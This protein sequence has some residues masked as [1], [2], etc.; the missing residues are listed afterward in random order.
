[1]PKGAK[2][3]SAKGKGTARTP[4]RRRLDV[5]VP[6]TSSAVDAATASTSAET[7]PK[8]RTRALENS[9]NE[10]SF[11]NL[12]S[13]YHGVNL[14]PRKLDLIMNAPTPREKERA[15]KAKELRKRIERES[16]SDSDSE[17]KHEKS[18]DRPRRKVARKRASPVETD[19][20]SEEE[21]A[22]RDIEVSDSGSDYAPSDAMEEG[23]EQDFS[24]FEHDQDSEGDFQPL[25]P[26]ISDSDSSTQSEAV[27]PRRRII[28]VSTRRRERVTGTVRRG[29]ARARARGRGRGR[30]RPT[31]DTL[32]EDPEDIANGWNLDNTA[33]TKI[34]F[35]GTPGLTCEAPTTVLGFFQLFFPLK[36]LFFLM[37]ETNDYA[38]YVR[39]ELKKPS[40]YHWIGCTLVDIA[41]YIGMV[42]WM[43]VIRLPE[44]RMYWS[45]NKT[46]SLANFS[47][48]MSRTKYEMMAKYFHTYNRRAI[49]KNNQDKLIVLRPVMEFIQDRCKSVYM[50]R[51]NLSL[52]EGILKWKGRLSI[53]IYNPMK[54][55]KYGIKFY[56]LCE[57][58][59]GYVLDFNVY[60]G[61]SSS[62]RDIV[63]NLME[64]HL[65]KGHHLFMDNYYNQVS[66]CD[67]LYEK[68]THCSGT[69]RLGRGG[70]KALQAIKAAGGLQTG[71]MAYRRKDNTFIICWQD[72][73][74]VSMITN[75]YNADTEPY[76]HKRRDPTIV[77][78]PEEQLQRPVVI[79]QYVS[80]MGGVD[81]FDQLINYYKF[82]KR[83][84]RWTRKTIFYL[85]QL[86]LLNA[87]VLY[88]KYGQPHPRRRR[89]LSLREFHQEIADSLLFFDPAE[90]PDDNTRLPHAP[91]LPVDE[92]QDKL[93]TPSPPASPQLDDPASAPV[94]PQVPAATPPVPAATPPV[95]AATPPLPANIPPAARPSTTPTRVV[96]DP[97]SRLDRSP[98]HKPE[99][100]PC[101]PGQRVQR[102]CRVCVMQGKRG[103]SRFQCSVCKIALCVKR[104]CFKRY[105]KLQYY[106][107]ASEADAPD[108][109]Q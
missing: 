92:R 100:I 52:D 53:K 41:K 46:Y 22:R 9:D 60:R 108:D 67:E 1:M 96:R 19:T 93:P 14:T 18:R 34:P 64:P 82:A 90:W 6:S 31:V 77:I 45:K 35:I 3:S 88:V 25:F 21:L 61:V 71:Q 15:R 47:A 2:E 51:E 72:S 58:E 16:S 63:F 95:P 29:R 73:R 57:A 83:S 7:Q 43:G 8:P 62:L 78:P 74:L 79:R 11:E 94:S 27:T 56:F 17:G 97:S 101:A 80:Y 59:S 75:R 20:D 81:L 66:T 44:T 106:W 76:I 24:G 37:E 33:P 54:P 28:S 49:P 99:L 12:L 40:R 70:P 87:Y 65:Y 23:I 39:N 13:L 4:A 104:D 89:Q 98:A 69:L 86:A 26:D 84:A 91:S 36:L 109:P 5:G 32:Q 38:N 30:R 107:R 105:H 55:I 10:G 85:L 42:M 50:P 102:R 48:T 68:G 103:D